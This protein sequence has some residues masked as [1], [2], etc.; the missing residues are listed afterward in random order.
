MGIVGCVC[1]G[2]GGACVCACVSACVRACVR[3]VVVGSHDCCVHLLAN[4][5][6]SVF[7]TLYT[8]GMIAELC[9]GHIL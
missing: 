1:G 3:V 6:N 4:W 5:C 7:C 8:C 9:I 2:E